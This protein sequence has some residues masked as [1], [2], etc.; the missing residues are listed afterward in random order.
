M[1][2]VVRLPVSWVNSMAWAFH[3]PEVS[4]TN[5]TKMWVDVRLAFWL[6]WLLLHDWLQLQQWFKCYWCG[7]LHK[8]QGQQRFASGQGYLSGPIRA[9]VIRSKKSNWFPWLLVLALFWWMRWHGLWNIWLTRST[10]LEMQDKFEIGRYDLSCS[11]LMLGFLMHKYTIA[12]FRLWQKYHFEQRGCRD[13]R[14]LA[15]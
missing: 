3:A 12:S 11:R 7:S 10:I 15:Q 13:G 14:L 1:T 6:T 5:G 9:L 8:C 2:A 4:M